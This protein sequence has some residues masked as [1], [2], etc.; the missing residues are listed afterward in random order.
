MKC[1]FF[2]YGHSR[3]SKRLNSI[4]CTSLIPGCIQILQWIWKCTNRKFIYAYKYGSHGVDLYETHNYPAKF[5]RHLYRSSY[6]SDEKFRM[7]GQNSICVPELYMAFTAPLS[8][9]LIMTQWYS[10]EIF[11]A[12]FHPHRLRNIERIGRNLFLPRTWNR[13]VTRLI[14]IKLTHVRQ[15][16][17]RIPVPNLV[18]STR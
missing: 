1:V 8:T 7:Y 13:A 15:I 3:N 2:L 16:C 18:S 10:V 14:S 17:K 6:K 9:K 11:C 5:Y 4:R 12:E